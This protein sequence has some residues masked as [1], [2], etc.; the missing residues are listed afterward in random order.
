MPRAAEAFTHGRVFAVFGPPGAGVTTLVRSLLAESTAASG[1]MWADDIEARRKTT[2]AEVFFLDGYPKTVD[3]VQR[4]YDDRW[5]APGFGGAIVRVERA[6]LPRA[7]HAAFWRALDAVEARIFFL[8]IPYFVLHN[9]VPTRA[10]IELA[11][12]TGLWR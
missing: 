8:G 3:D 1:I 6:A 7:A 10:V 11:G 5:T 9:D 12:R 4:L 2:N